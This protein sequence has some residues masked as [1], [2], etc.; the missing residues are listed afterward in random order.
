[1]VTSVTFFSLLSHEDTKWSHDHKGHDYSQ[2]VHYYQGV[3]PY[4]HYQLH[5]CYQGDQEVHGVLDHLDHQLVQDYQQVPQYQDYP[6]I[7][8]A[9]NLLL[10]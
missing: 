2:L 9:Y 8:N 10:W 1:M 6:S 3:H 5:L 7:H 4:H